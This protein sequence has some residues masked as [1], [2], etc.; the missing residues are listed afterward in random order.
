MG[1][2]ALWFPKWLAA[3][4]LSMVF[5]FFLVYFPDKA[6]LPLWLRALIGH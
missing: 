5:V 6:F 1:R 3:V 4:Y 2:S